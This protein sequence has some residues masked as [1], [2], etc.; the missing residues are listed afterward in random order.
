M[1]K[2]VVVNGTDKHGITW[3]M[4][5]A[6]LRGF[7]EDTKVREFSLPSD[8]PDFCNGCTR[9]ISNGEHACPGS[10]AV[11]PIAQ[12]LDSADLMVF[13]TPVYVYHATGAMK[14]LLDHFAYRWMPHRPSR[15]MFAKRA[16]IITQCAGMG[17]R[18]AAG[19][20]KDSLAWWG[21][22]DIQIVA[23]RTGAAYSSVRAM[24]RILDRCTARG[25]KMRRR[26][27][28]TPR[29]S[30]AVR[31]RFYMCKLLQ[32]KLAQ[33]FPKSVDVAYWKDQGWLG[34]VTPWDAKG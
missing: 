22:P 33:E 29:T 19:D 5:D 18:T 2:V 9:C 27:R 30:A 31:V 14:N 16:V 3:K 34:N 24:N 28:N 4:K 12:A 25:Q 8:G 17:I 6:F 15:A 32:R 20:L 21:V 23:A 11:K 7:G 1:R 10:A 26:M 13:T